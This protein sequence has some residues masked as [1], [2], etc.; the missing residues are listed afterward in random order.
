MQVGDAA[1]QLQILVK[2]KADSVS[3]VCFFL[4]EGMNCEVAF[5]AQKVE[6]G[7]RRTR[8]VV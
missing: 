4:L 7:G 1:Q 2:S 3:F 5:P 6:F 8:D